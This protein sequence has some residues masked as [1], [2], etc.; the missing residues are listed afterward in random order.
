MTISYFDAMNLFPESELSGLPPSWIFLDPQKWPKKKLDEKPDKEADPTA[1][2]N[3][4]SFEVSYIMAIVS[5][6]FL[7][8]A[9]NS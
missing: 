4:T 7:G 1:K 6:I 8:A 2:K 9:V 3:L 5:F